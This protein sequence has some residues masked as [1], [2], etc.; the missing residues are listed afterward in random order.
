MKKNE[1]VKDV[2][3]IFFTDGCDTCNT[4]PQIMDYLDKL[5]KYF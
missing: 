2:S 4:K 1:N 5:K 3:I